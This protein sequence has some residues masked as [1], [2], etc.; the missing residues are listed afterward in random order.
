MSTVKPVVNIADVPLRDHGNGTKFA[1]KLGEVGLALGGTGVGCM[2]NEVPP[3]KR[4][5]PFHVH[6]A[7]HELFFIIEGTGTYRFGKDTYPIRAGDVCA[8]PPGGPEVA[9]QIINDGDKVLKY[10]SF[11]TEMKGAEIVE[12]PELGQVHRDRAR[13]RRCDAAVPLH[14]PQ[15]NG[16]RLL[17][18]R[19]MSEAKDLISNIDDVELKEQAHGKSFQALTKSV[20]GSLG[21][22]T[23]GVSVLSVPPGKRAWPFHRHHIIEEAFFIVSGSGEY[24]YGAD[25]FPVK[26][27]DIVAA[28]AG[29]EAHQLVN[30]GTENLRYLALSS[31]HGGV[32]IVEYPDTGKVAIAAGIKNRDFRTA[33]IRAMGKITPQDYWEGEE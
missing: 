8:A 18:G 30:T 2:Y 33:T 24:R 20:G 4:A 15:G 11:S 7:Q 25:T 31:S 27:G 10:L 26:A 9:H 3:G 1:A 21:L 13:R 17:G 23:L 5:F 14:R 29:G 22:T 19:G 28:P 6:H 16:R 32:D 12:L